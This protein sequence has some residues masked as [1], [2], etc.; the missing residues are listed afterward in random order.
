MWHRINSYRDHYAE[1][2]VDDSSLVG[3]STATSCVLPDD[4]L[5]TEEQMS[6]EDE[7]Q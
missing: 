6:D 3:T 7:V 2:E 4:D 5:V 1:H